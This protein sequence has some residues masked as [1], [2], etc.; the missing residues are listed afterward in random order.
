MAGVVTHLSLTDVTNVATGIEWWEIQA[1]LIALTALPQLVLSYFLFRAWMDPNEQVVVNLL[2]LKWLIPALVV[3]SI[4]G[5]VV[6]Q[7]P[8][9][10]QLTPAVISTETNATSIDCA[11]EYGAEF[12][13]WWPVKDVDTIG[14]E[15]IAHINAKDCRLLDIYIKDGPSSPEVF[16]KTISDVRNKGGSPWIKARWVK[17]HLYV[18]RWEFVGLTNVCEHCFQSYAQLW[19]YSS[20]SDSGTRLFQNYLG[21]V[22]SQLFKKFEVSSDEQYVALNIRAEQDLVTTS[23]SSPVFYVGDKVYIFA[24]NYD[25]P[26]YVYSPYQ[27]SSPALLSF[28]NVAKSSPDDLYVNLEGWDSG[29]PVL[30]GKIQRRWGH[31][32]PPIFAGQ[33]DFSINAW[34]DNIFYD[35][36]DLNVNP[37]SGKLLHSTEYYVHL[38]YDGYMPNFKPESSS[39]GDYDLQTISRYIKFAKTLTDK[40]LV[41][42][43]LIDGKVLEDRYRDDLAFKYNAYER[44][45]YNRKL[46]DNSFEAIHDKLLAKYGPCFGIPDGQCRE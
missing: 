10:D 25:W 6:M 46:V 36:T 19:R 3:G 12:D 8:I 16:F 17:H 43:L 2:V 5:A 29:A 7:I 32:D 27:L 45:A 14:T 26:P 9:P 31:G 28:P 4:W 24:M 22:R 18:V 20:S 34:S 35:N 38:N 15:V 1:L 13:K 37:T 23:S 40:D 33:N 11:K 44:E 21:T 41:K 42:Q 30:R 39:Q